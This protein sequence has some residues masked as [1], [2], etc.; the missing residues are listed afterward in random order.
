MS[1]PD[2]V[3]LERFAL[4]VLAGG[5][6]TRYGGTAKGMLRL[7]D[8][9]TVLART[10]A[11]ARAAGLSHC[12][13]VANDE[14]AYRGCGCRV[15]PD[16]N[17]GKGPLGGIEAAFAHF[18]GDVDHMVILP[19]DVPEFGAVELMHLIA[20]YM[21]AGA[22]LAV[23]ETPDGLWHPLC[24]VLRTETR[25]AVSAAVAGAE[26]SV[27][28]LWR[29]LGAVSVVFHDEGPFLNLNSPGDMARVPRPDVGR[30]S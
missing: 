29:S 20:G 25:G 18:G 4:A 17:P 3:V 14:A 15:V 8:G 11:A 6:A 5:R 30:S 19:C 10:L 24:A 1:V 13:V 26:L 27:N 22:P 16:L 28:R 12:L 9:R 7:P 21:E 2:A 23:A